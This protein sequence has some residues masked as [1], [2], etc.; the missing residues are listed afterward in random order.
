MEQ[1]GGNARDVARALDTVRPSDVSYVMAKT[2]IKG[3]V[4]AVEVHE[5]DIGSPAK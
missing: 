4:N 1:I 3:C 2:P 5:F